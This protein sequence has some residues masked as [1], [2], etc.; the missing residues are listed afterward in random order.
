MIGKREL[1]GSGE[2]VPE[3]GF[4]TWRYKGGV[5][6]LIR[7]IELGANFIDT[8]EVYRTEP[9]VAQALKGRREGV[10]L[11]TK[12]SGD[13]LRYDQ[14]LRAADE[15]L[16]RLG[17]KVIDL[18][19]VHWPDPL[20]PIKDTMRAMEE[21]V[22]AGKVR[23]IGVSNFTRR[24]FEEAQGC[25]TK[26]KIVANQVEYSLSDRTI[27]PD[28]EPLYR[29]GKVS[30]I[31]Y[32]PLAQGALLYPGQTDQQ[33]ALHEVALETGKTEAQVSLAWC[34]RIPEVI[35]IPKT[36]HV[37]RVDE[38]CGAAGWQLTPDQIERLNRA[39]P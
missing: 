35:A 27:E 9:T 30:I 5:D 13:H 10:F 28:I 8:A 21:L 2:M 25:L 12:V 6:P 11:A 7:A 37:E 16:E 15:S 14:V 19:Q 33:R 38:D 36:D 22:D 26:Y 3:I 20:V 24:E 32:S 1:G 39:F 29:K 4:G 17:T 23:Y 34:L 31:A 18:Y